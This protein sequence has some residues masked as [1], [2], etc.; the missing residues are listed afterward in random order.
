MDT[1][2]E[3]FYRQFSDETP[4]GVFHKVVALHEAPDSSWQEL[5]RTVPALPRGWFEL[6]QLKSEERIAMLR[7]FWLTKLPFCPHIV[8]RLDPFFNKL[9]D[10]GIYLIQ[11]RFDDPWKA[12]LVYS[13]K[14]DGGFFRGGPPAQEE[15]LY[16]LQKL[17]PEVILPE[18][19]VAFLTIHN[20]FSKATDTGLISTDQFEE[21]YR[22]YEALFAPDEIPTTTCGKPVNPHSLIPFYESFGMPYYQCFWTDWWPES[23]MGNVY[24]NGISKQI[25]S[26]ECA[27]PDTDQMAFKTFSDWLFFYL[28]TIS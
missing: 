6:S 16:D 7:D 22:V 19:Y 2:V 17:F 4:K 12:E 27:H 8:E 15:Q 26:V 21:R 23:E 9:D 1:H 11:K 20:G 3:K 13:L 10:I 5:S 28:E 14:D 25:S 24:L 18:D